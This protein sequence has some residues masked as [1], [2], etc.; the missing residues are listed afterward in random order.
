ME[1]LLRND[2]NEA[3]E[4]I[5]AKREQVGPEASTNVFRTKAF[6]ACHLVAMLVEVFDPY[7]KS[8]LLDFSLGRQQ[9]RQVPG[10][11]KSHPITWTSSTP[12]RGFFAFAVRRHCVVHRRPRGR[13]A[14]VCSRTNRRRV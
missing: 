7:I 9:T 11:K 13:V 12:M 10:V 2:V 1:C 4:L 5:L 6:N 3:N 14:R 8:R